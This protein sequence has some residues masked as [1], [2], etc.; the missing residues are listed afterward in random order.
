MMKKSNRKFVWIGLGLFLIV[1]IGIVLF[2]NL[3]Q[4]V[5]G[6]GSSN[7]LAIP[8]L[9]SEYS[10]S[11]DYK[12]SWSGDSYPYGEGVNYEVY[13]SSFSFPVN[14]YTQHGKSDLP[15]LVSGLN[16]ND[17]FNTS[18]VNLDG[19]TITTESNQVR[20]LII[21][22]KSAV[23]KLTDEG[24]FNSVERAGMKCIVS[25][26]FHIVDSS[27]NNAKG[28]VNG[29]TKGDITVKIYKE[30][31]ESYSNYYRLLDNSCNLINIKTFEKK[32][33]DYLTLNEC[34]S[35]IINLIDIENLIDNSNVIS[36]YTDGNTQ[37]TVLENETTITTINQTNGNIT[38]LYETKTQ[39]NYLMIGLIV[40]GSLIA[41]FLTLLIIIKVKRK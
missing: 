20:K 5:F 26:N 15:I 33:N 21:D 13:S 3:R 38:I 37:I 30:G 40:L 2:I 34:Q 28:S 14:W 35:K 1:L 29:F 25:G 41:I 4:S 39:I 36:N 32:S 9:I 27:G 17:W 7:V 31:Y 11:A 10:D 19:Y 8:S 22:D 23:C 18:D 16:T 12:I 24:L 6:T